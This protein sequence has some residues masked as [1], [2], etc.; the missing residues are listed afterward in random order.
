MRLRRPAAPGVV[1]AAVLAVL[2]LANLAESG[3]LPSWGPAGSLVVI[4]V[5]CGIVRWA[6]G[7]REDVGLGAGTVRRGAVWALALTGIVAS[8]YLI[9]AL[10]PLTRELFSDRLTAHL[11]GGQLALHMLVQVPLGTVLLEE[12]AFRGVLY[13]LVRRY[14]GT[15]TATAVS[16]VLFGLWHLLPALVAPSARTPGA[17]HL[18]AG[19]LPLGVVLFTTAAG[20]FLCELR[21]RSDSLLAPM[22]LHWATNALGYLTAFV[23]ARL[24]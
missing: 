19:A 9:G 24:G 5:L 4:A 11:D 20:V 10:L 1:L 15:A 2:A 12:F 23:L 6:G 7:S 3:F 17:A 16:S 8:V 22:G 21:R 14:S 13:G 18:P